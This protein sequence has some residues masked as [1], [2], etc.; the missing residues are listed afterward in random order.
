MKKVTCKECGSE[1]IS[2]VESLNPND[3]NTIR[4][5]FTDAYASDGG[6]CFCNDCVDQR[7]FQVVETPDEES[8]PWRC[9]ECGSLDVE[10]TDTGCM[11]DRNAYWCRNC[12]KHTRQVQESELMRTIEEWWGKTDFKQMERITGYRQSDYS[13]EDGYQ[14]FVDAGNV[15]WNGKTNN[16]KIEIWNEYK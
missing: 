4:E 10:Y 13:T 14:A 16:E 2:I 3:D 6:L 1:D 5:Y 12:E 7:E 9:S 8:D 15:W 11:G